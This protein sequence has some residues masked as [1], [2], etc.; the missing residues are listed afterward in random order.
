LAVRSAAAVDF[1]ADFA[2]LGM[3]FCAPVRFILIILLS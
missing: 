1:A 3:V 2:A